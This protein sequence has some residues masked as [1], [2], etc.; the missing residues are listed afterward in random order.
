MSETIENA[1]IVRLNFEAHGD[2]PTFWLYLRYAGDEGQG[3]GGYNIL[4]SPRL[5]R[6]IRNLLRTVGVKTTAELEGAYVRVKRRDMHGRNPV[7]IIGH[8]IENL[9]W[10]VRDEL[11]ERGVEHTAQLGAADHADAAAVNTPAL[12][13]NDRGQG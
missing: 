11:S 6:A 12:E 2:A 7:T 13:H 8:L 4:N 3:V 9:W 1:R 10:D 5:G